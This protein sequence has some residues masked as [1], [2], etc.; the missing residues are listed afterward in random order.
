M[1]AELLVHAAAPDSQVAPDAAPE[2]QP[3]RPGNGRSQQAQPPRCVLL[4]GETNAVGDVVQLAAKAHGR[5]S[6]LDP[7]NL[8][9]SARV[10][11]EEHTAVVQHTHDFAEQWRPV[12]EP[13][14]S[15]DVDDHVER[16]IGER[17]RHRV[18][19]KE[20]ERGVRRVV[21]LAERAR[22]AREVE[23][24]VERRAEAT[25]EARETPG[26][27]AADLEDARAPVPAELLQQIAE[28]VVHLELE[29]LGVRERRRRETVVVR[30]RLAPIEPVHEVVLL[31]PGP[32]Q[33]GAQPLRRAPEE[34]EH[35]EPEV[36]RSTLHT[37]A[38]FMAAARHGCAPRR[39]GSK[40]SWRVLLDPERTPQPD[41]SSL[42]RPHPVLASGQR[43]TLAETSRGRAP[44]RAAW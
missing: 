36:D 19:D 42:D 23:P 1:R 35:A 29:A 6:R 31:P 24:D 39:K 4:A 44:Q 13:I 12:P 34:R 18:A 43:D 22:H 7:R 25:R 15:L 3:I 17:Q 26:T 2:E 32:E 40:E 5:E 37:R 28:R 14:R 11:V 9:K 27:S 20:A 8:P 16:R 33:R 38:R 30:G 21:T 10:R 41:R